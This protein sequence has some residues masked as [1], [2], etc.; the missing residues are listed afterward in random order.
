[1]VQSSTNASAGAG[2]DFSAIQLVDVSRVRVYNAFIGVKI[3]GCLTVN[4]D[5]VDTT[6]GIGWGSLRPNSCGLLLT[7]TGSSLDN[8]GI[9]MVNCN[10]YGS[11]GLGEGSNLNYACLIQTVDGLMCNNTHFSFALNGFVA[12]PSPGTHLDLISV[13]N[14]GFDTCPGY[15]VLFSNLTCLASGGHA[16]DHSYFNQCGTGLAYDAPTSNQTLSAIGIVDCPFSFTTGDGIQLRQGNGFTVTGNRF[17]GVNFGN[18]FTNNSCVVVSGGVTNFSI[19]GNSYVRG[20][21]TLAL[22][23]VYVKTNASVGSIIGNTSSGLT[24]NLGTFITVT[25]QA[26]STQFSNTGNV[27]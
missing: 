25:N 21:G 1:M 7:S 26:N 13:G 15:G 10:F 8:A 6:A 3:A 23:L 14:S 2:L 24:T 18:P 4:M 5:A 9:Q 16:I 17:M 20:S 11:T 27:P 22:A 12:A 19:M